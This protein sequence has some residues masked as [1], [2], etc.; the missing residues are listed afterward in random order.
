MA[1]VGFYH[2]TRMNL[3]QALPALLVRTLQQKEKAVV[4]CRDGHQV[5][6]LTEVLWNVKDPV[7]LP[8]GCHTD[9]YQD[10]FPQWQPIWLT[11]F[12]ENPNNAAYLFLVDGHLAE[13]TGQF[14]RVFDLFDGTDEQAVQAAR[15]RWQALKKQGD[16][17]LT[18]WKQ[19][20]KGWQKG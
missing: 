3:E 5:K 17:E 16:H 6:S 11:M 18:Y 7:W 4:L 14:R 15:K 20:E 2:L 13:E 8:H 19:T 12:E 10:Q 1:S 9:A